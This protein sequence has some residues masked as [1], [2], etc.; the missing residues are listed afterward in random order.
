VAALEKNEL[1]VLT[2]GTVCDRKGQIDVIEAA[3]QLNLPTDQKIRCI[4]VGDRPGDYSDRANAAL[5]G[6]PPLKRSSV[7]I[8][9][10]T[11]D[12]ALYYSAADVFACTSRIESFPR[13]ILEAMAAG[14]PIVTTPVYGIVEQV[15][16]NINALFYRPGDSGAL[17]E[18][19]GDLVKDADLRRRLA[20][21]S[22]YVLDTL[23]DYEMMVSAYAKVFREAWLSGRTRKCAASSE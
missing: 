14:L 21:N 2:V 7:E 10:E 15:Q 22:R 6:L 18:R 23:N 9:P 16:E 17:A 12:V 3:G 5:R 11:S 13:V 19:L 1:M 4:I 20:E 8:F